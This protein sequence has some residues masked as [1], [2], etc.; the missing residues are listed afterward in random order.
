LG[1]VKVKHPDGLS[2]QILVLGHPFLLGQIQPIHKLFGVDDVLQV[3]TGEDVAFADWHT[4]AVTVEETAH[5]ERSHD[6]FLVVL[7]PEDELWLRIVAAENSLAV[8]GDYAGLELVIC[9][10]ALQLLKSQGQ[11]MRLDC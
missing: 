10:S 11:R 1:F 7:V 8:I 9:L 6:E 3:L 4:L 2:G 5:S